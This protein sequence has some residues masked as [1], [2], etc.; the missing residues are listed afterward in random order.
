MMVAFSLPAQNTRI[1]TPFWYPSSYI[2]GFVKGCKQSVEQFQP[3]FTKKLWPDDV[4]EVCGCV[5]DSL[6]HSLTWLEVQNDMTLENLYGDGSMQLNKAEQDYSKFGPMKMAA[7]ATHDLIKG[8]KLTMDDV[9]FCRTSQSTGISQIDL[10]QVIDNKLVEDVKIN[11][12]I[13]WNHI[14]ER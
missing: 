7:V 6:R 12:V 2:Y 9:H 13:D 4:T 8:S 5:V 11:Q 10:L 14:R 3:D 1:A